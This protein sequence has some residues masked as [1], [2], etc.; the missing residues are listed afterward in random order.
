MGRQYLAAAGEYLIYRRHR[1]GMG[2]IVQSIS[3]HPDNGKSA[4]GRFPTGGALPLS[5]R[6]VQDA[7]TSSKGSAGRSGNIAGLSC[8]RVGIP[9]SCRSSA[10]GCLYRFRYQA[11][12]RL[13]PVH[14]DA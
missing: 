4:C 2:K 13:F 11:G 10:S 9:L 6:V 14:Y 8:E 5:G 3:H 12:L 7:G 1:K